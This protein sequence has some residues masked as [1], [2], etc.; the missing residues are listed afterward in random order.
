MGVARTAGRGRE[1]EPSNCLHEHHRISAD[2][3]RP[4][5]LP[6]LVDYFGMPIEESESSETEGKNEEDNV[7]RINAFDFGY[8]ASDADVALLSLLREKRGP[9]V[10]E[11]Y[12]VIIHQG[13][14]TSGHYYAFI[15][16]SSQSLACWRA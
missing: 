9:Y 16:N 12:S 1:K 7:D 6:L 4:D 13:T 11:L 5:D 15:K 3:A 8:S 10:Y 14:V 2:C